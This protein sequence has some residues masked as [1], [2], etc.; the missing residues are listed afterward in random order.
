LGYSSQTSQSGLC[1]LDMSLSRTSLILHPR[2]IC[3]GPRSGPHCGYS[4][5]ARSPDRRGPSRVGR[6]VVVCEVRCGLGCEALR[7]I[8]C[9]VRRG[10]NS[11]DR[12]D[13]ISPNRSEAHCSSRCSQNCDTLSSDNCRDQHLAFYP[14]VSRCSQR[15]SEGYSAPTNISAFPWSCFLGSQLTPSAL[16]T[17]GIPL[18]HSPLHPSVFPSDFASVY[19]SVCPSVFAS[20]CPSVYPSV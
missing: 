2:P 20:V 6:S 1:F 11:T 12:C 16:V 9:G 17:K 13:P 4:S 10:S 5:R 19:P 3:G 15:L 8:R 7:L 18:I 14:F